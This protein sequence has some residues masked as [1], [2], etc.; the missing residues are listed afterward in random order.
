[1]SL[2]T[3]ENAKS[4]TILELI[5][6]LMNEVENHTTI[7][8][9][10]KEEEKDDIQ[11]AIDYLIQSGEL[12]EIVG[13]A[14]E[15]EI[16]KGKDINHPPYRMDRQP[17]RRFD[18]ATVLSITNTGQVAEVMG[19]RS[20]QQLADYGDRD[21]VLTFTMYSGPEPDVL[22]ATGYTNKSVEVAS[23]GGLDVC[24]GDIID[25]M[26]S[27]SY[28][29]KYDISQRMSSLVSHVD[30]EH[31]IIFVEGWYSPG[32]PSEGQVPNHLV[33]NH[34]LI[35]PIT[36]IWNHNSIA[37]MHEKSLA[38]SGVIGEYALI[39]SKGVY[40]HRLSG[41]DVVNFCGH[42]E[43]CFVARSTQA[44]PPKPS[45]MNYG[46]LSFSDSIGNGF[47]AKDNETGFVADNCRKVAFRT[48]NGRF[49]VNGQGAFESESFAH[50]DVNAGGGMIDVS[51]RPIS[52]IT[53]AG[54]YNLTYAD[55]CPE[56]FVRL[57]NTQ[58]DGDVRINGTFWT[59]YG[60]VS[61]VK[62][63]FGRAMELYS[64]GILWY[65]VN[66]AIG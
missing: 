10:L 35:N 17:K 39:N 22:I 56:R 51:Q 53:A 63:P 50:Q 2:F 48:N 43:A 23:F 11:K 14:I 27:G 62:V 24:P 5:Y 29:G 65:V 13:R 64:N 44:F 42:N 55:Q 8:N 46:Y 12:D 4:H 58:R 38:T 1:M 34:V 21:G 20:V 26:P 66:A 28:V 41:I 54:E 6:Q 61:Q 31:N 9:Q 60:V 49:L 33:Q 47:A 16:F 30:K 59:E 36:K 45:L 18:D 15:E 32:N 3:V 7:I 40:E 52:I 57:L 19:T 37:V 25:V